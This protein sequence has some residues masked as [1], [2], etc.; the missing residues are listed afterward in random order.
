MDNTLLYLVDLKKIEFSESNGNKAS[1][2]QALTPGEYQHP[3]FGKL[4]I[5]AD[6]IKNLAESV[7]TKVRGIDPSIN[8]QHQGDGEAAG[9]VKDAESRA[10]GLWLFVEWTTDAARKIKEKAFRYFSAEYH[11]T[12]KDPAGND[13]TDVFFG[14]ALTNRPYMKNLIPVNLSEST[15]DVAYGL[16]EAINNAKNANKGKEVQVDLAELNKKL[17]LPEG[18]SEADALKKLS[19]L[20]A[21]PAGDQSKF[22]KVPAAPSA[23]AE[24]V[25]LAEENPLVAALLTTLNDQNTALQEFN[26]NLLENSIA[27]K[28]AEFDQSKIVLTP[29]AKDMVHDFL[30]DTPVELHE[31]FWDIM[32][33][34]RKSSGLMVELGERAGAN[35]RYGRAKDKASLFMDEANKLVIANKITLSEAMDQVA[36]SQPDLYNG[37]R[38]EIYV[39]A[40]E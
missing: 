18:T 24:L 9:W 34:M 25:A 28:L 26:S 2:I 4:N 23:S 22:P 5:T 3:V 21:P 40:S 12:W 11:D 33:S 32:N 16:V 35:V 8:Y 10:D 30:V 38:S 15:V 7:K 13:H 37:Y 14:G 1:W 39:G 19:E 6:K 17:G 20:T 29:K 27:T 36:R 31:R